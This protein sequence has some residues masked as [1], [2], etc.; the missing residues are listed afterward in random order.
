MDSPTRFKPSTTGSRRVFLKSS[1]GALASSVAVPLVA[2]AVIHAAGS[3]LL[4]V[5]LVGCGGR[6]TGAGSQALRADPNV[7]LTALADA[8]EDHLERSLREL[9]KDAEILEKIDVP[10]DRRFVG[11]DAFR[12]L[13]DSGV[14]VGK[15]HP[16]LCRKLRRSGC[17]L[18]P[19]LP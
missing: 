13:I 11:F 6:G 9:Q 17:F 14:D 15:Y 5:G 7:R 1:A 8:F 19:G 10:R 4:R 2:P 3:D 18:S 12:Q 16:F